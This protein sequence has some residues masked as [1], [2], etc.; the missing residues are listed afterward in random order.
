MSHYYDPES[1]CTMCHD[2]LCM[3]DEDREA[4]ELYRDKIKPGES[5][6]YKCGK[7]IKEKYLKE[8]K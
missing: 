6:C 7:E 4:E 2:W 8:G 5:I 1:R 3:F